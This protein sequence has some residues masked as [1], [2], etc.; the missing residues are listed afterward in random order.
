MWRTSLCLPSRASAPPSKIGASRLDDRDD[1]RLVLGLVTVRKAADLADR[2]RWQKHGGGAGV[3]ASQLRRGAFD[4]LIARAGPR[5]RRRAIPAIARS[6][7]R[8]RGV[9]DT[10]DRSPRNEEIEQRLDLNRSAVERRLRLIR[11]I[12]VRRAQE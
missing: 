2:E 1:L 11:S 5:P 8:R 12:R 4:D 9:G 6:A 3:A 7:G 10:G